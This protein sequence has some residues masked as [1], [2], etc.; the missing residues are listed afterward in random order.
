MKEKLNVTKSTGSDMT[1]PMDRWESLPMT[2]VKGL[3]MIQ[4][5]SPEVTGRCVEEF[6][7][8]T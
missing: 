5:R 2:M 7:F 1:V 3:P 6:Q 8:V 4:R